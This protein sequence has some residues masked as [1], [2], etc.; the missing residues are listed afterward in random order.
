MKMKPG[1]DV[2]DHI[3][4]VET[5]A[6]QLTDLGEMVSDQAIICKIL[7]SLPSSYRHLLS[8]WDSVPR[9]EQS[10]EYLT[11]QLLKEET[12]NKLQDQAE[13]EG[14]KAFFSKGSVLGQWPLST[15]ERK[16]R[17]AKIAELKKKTNYKKCGKKGH[18][19]TIRKMLGALI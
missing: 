14:E 7:C 15:E 2:V 5:L 6:C 12:R 19:P 13:E 1:A 11:L 9:C 8:A 18:V 17:A 4:A 10:I 16:R 3:S